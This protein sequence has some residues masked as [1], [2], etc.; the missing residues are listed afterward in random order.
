MAQNQDSTK[1]SR[2]EEWSLVELKKQ[3]E[4]VK[5]RTCSSQRAFQQ[6]VKHLQ[7]ETRKSSICTGKAIYRERKL[8]NT[9]VTAGIA[10]VN[11][12]FQ[13]QKAEQGGSSGN[14]RKS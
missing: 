10:S 7:V 4:V 9:D 12:C 13:S 14:C 5:T 8:I 3:W 1:E 2:L 11:D 6:R